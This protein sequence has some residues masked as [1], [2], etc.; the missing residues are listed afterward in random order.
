MLSAL[1]AAPHPNVVRMLDYYVHQKKLFTVYSLADATLWS[2]FKS[3]EVQGRRISDERLGRYM[4][5]VSA[6]L[7]HLHQFMIVHADASLKN[8][9]LTRDDRI[10]VGDFG[11]AHSAHGHLIGRDC[12]LQATE[13]RETG[14][15]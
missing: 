5:D 15:P 8:M 4:F 6:G 1:G 11:A 13:S 10:Q 14:T 7:A 3:D 12:D 2:I 9:L